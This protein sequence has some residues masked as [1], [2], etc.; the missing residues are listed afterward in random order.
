MGTA[1][2]TAWTAGGGDRAGSPSRGQCPGMGAS[3]GAAG[4]HLRANKRGLGAAPA[5]LC[6]C[7]R[8]SGCAWGSWKCPSVSVCPGLCLWG[9]STCPY[10]RPG[11]SVSACPSVPASSRIPVCPRTCPHVSLRHPVC[12]QLPSASPQPRLSVP[13]P[14]VPARPRV[15]APPRVRSSALCACAGGSGRPRAAHAQ[16]GRAGGAGPQCARAV[17]RRCGGGAARAQ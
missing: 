8:P 9:C 4:L 1:P 16:C 11:C 7:V 2:C 6:G 17:K 10:V 15:A 14:R 5:A 13:L 12:S 3:R